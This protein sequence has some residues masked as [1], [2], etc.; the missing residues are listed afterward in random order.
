MLPAL[1]PPTPE[2]LRFMSLLP[3]NARGLI[4]V[5]GG[6]DGDLARH[7]KQVYAGCFYQG[8]ESDA[9]LAGLARRHCDVVHQADI[10]Q[11]GDAFFA[12]FAMADCW[13]FDQVLER[14][15]QPWA[16][17]RAIRQHIAPD[18]CIV[19]RVPN[20]QYWSL[21]ARLNGGTFHYQEGGQLPRAQLRHFSRSTLLELLRDTG[22]RMS[23]GN[24][25]NGA[26]PP[27]AVAEA[28][29]ALALRAG[30]DPEQ[31]L[32]DALASHYLIKAVPV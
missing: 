31:A 17:L 10:E 20:G 22:F 15:R 18:A 9:R 12:H 4:E 25:L 6:A 27:P 29:R 7:Y 14:L 11:A 23:A 2:T 3:P 28:L 13:I 26:P 21:Q 1:A 24:P 5:G 8:V 16:V 19:A 30:A 32:Q